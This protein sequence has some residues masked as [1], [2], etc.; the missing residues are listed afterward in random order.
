[1]EDAL[2]PGEDPTSQ[3]A[4]DADHW[5]TVYSE[6][7]QTKAA[8]L[9]ALSR[10]LALTTSEAA[11]RELGETDA[12]M[13]QAEVERFQRRLDF[14]KARQAELSRDEDRPSP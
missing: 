2:L 11:R 7:M 14:W 12:A 4:D 13:L 5:L 6:L 1:M 10:R 8:M 3:A 9:S